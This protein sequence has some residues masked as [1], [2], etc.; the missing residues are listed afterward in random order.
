[1]KINNTHRTSWGAKTLDSAAIAR[2][3]PS[4]DVIGVI[5]I[6]FRKIESTIPVYQQVNYKVSKE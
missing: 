3:E 2:G 4:E 6:S 5:L 1:M